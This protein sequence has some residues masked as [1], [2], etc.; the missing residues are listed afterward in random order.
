MG[1]LVQ[2]EAVARPECVSQVV[3]LLKHG[4]PDTR[5]SEGCRDITAYLN[6]DGRT[7]VVIEHWDSKEQYRRYLA[8]RTEVGAMERLE[9][10]LEVPLNIRFFSAVDA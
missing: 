7:F 4:F 3:Q 5:S 2:V 1:I 8:W 10:L 9:A 6:E